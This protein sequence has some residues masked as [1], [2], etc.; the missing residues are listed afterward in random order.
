MKIIV[1]SSKGGVGKSTVS[2]Q[3]ITP[4]LYEKNNFEPIN[5]YECD[6]ENQDLRSYGATELINRKQVEVETPYLRDELTSIFTSNDTVCMD[7]G[8]NKTTSLV[9]K[10][11]DESGAISFV[12]VCVIPLLDGE[13]DGINAS[14][15]YAELKSLNKD[16]TFIFVLNRV[17][18]LKF[19]EYQFDN[20]FGD[21]RGI[22]SDVNSLVHYVSDDDIYQFV[23]M[24]DAE[25]IKYSR[26]FGLTAYE[27]AKQDRD[28]IKQ[29]KNNPQEAN[30]LSFKNYVGKGAKKYYEDSLLP[31][32]KRIDEIIK[33]KGYK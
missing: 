29:I 11:L 18:N 1:A 16:M 17:R 25:V 22:F 26:K 10:A 33:E 9:I 12:D 24:L 32:F 7:I 20:Y 5:Y 27:I 21:L 28:F 30:V 14:L 23:P 13:Q 31:A 2:M 6:D 3:L 4:Y 15:V 8:G 19:I